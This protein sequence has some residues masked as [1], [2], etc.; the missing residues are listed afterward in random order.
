MK[1]VTNFN[2]STFLMNKDSL[3]KSVSQRLLNGTGRRVS[4]GIRAGSPPD[5]PDSISPRKGTKLDLAPVG[6]YDQDNGVDP[7]VREI[8][9]QEKI[10]FDYGVYKDEYQ[11]DE[12]DIYVVIYKQEREIDIAKVYPKAN[13]LVSD[14]ILLIIQYLS[15]LESLTEESFDR[16]RISSDYSANCV[17]IEVVHNS[18]QSTTEKSYLY[19]LNSPDK[20]IYIASLVDILIPRILTIAKSVKNQNKL[21]AGFHREIL[22]GSIN[23]LIGKYPSIDIPYRRVI[24]IRTLYQKP[25]KPV[26]MLACRNESNDSGLSIKHGSKE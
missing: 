7:R 9:F 18:D 25:W 6:N 22:T 3:V 23:S 24:E 20:A 15:G 17:L 11:L 14:I 5:S 10:N 1:I 2:H 16:A 13:I 12:K 19:L 4:I 21:P 26:A 8:S